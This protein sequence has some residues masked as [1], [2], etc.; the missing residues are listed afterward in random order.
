MVAGLLIVEEGLFEEENALMVVICL[1][2]SIFAQETEAKGRRKRVN[3]FRKSRV[4]DMAGMKEG[5]LALASRCTVFLI[6]AP[7]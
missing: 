6:F 4:P 5:K 3:G 1:S 7:T 2:D